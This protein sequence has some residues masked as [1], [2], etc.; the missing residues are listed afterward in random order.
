MDAS[1][2]DP[3]LRGGDVIPAEAGIPFLLAVLEFEKQEIEALVAG[4]VA[5]AEDAAAV[6]DVGEAQ[7]EPGAAPARAHEEIAVG[8]E[9][10]VDVAHQDAAELGVDA[11]RAAD[12][13]GERDAV[14]VLPDVERRGV[15]RDAAHRHA[16]FVDDVGAEAD[17]ALAEVGAAVESVRDATEEKNEDDCG[18]AH[19]AC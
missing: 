16:F 15:E 17:A 9:V 18:T 3:R 10:L 14:V 12:R 19:P 8:A 11:D 13:V 7:A 1:K 4:V 6:R 5:D 2:L